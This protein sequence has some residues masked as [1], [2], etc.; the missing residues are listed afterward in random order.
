MNQNAVN[1]LQENKEKYSKEILIKQLQNSGYGEEDINEAVKDVFGDDVP[2]GASPTGEVK[3]AGFWI[4]WVAVLLDGFIFVI[5]IYLNVLLQLI[6]S[7][8]IHEKNSS[9]FYLVGYLPIPIMVVYYIFMTNKYQATLGK[10]ALGLKVVAED[11]QRAELGK[12]VLR[13]TVGKI[14]SAI[15]LGIGYIMAGFTQKKQALHDM[16]A[17]T[18]VVY[19][20]PSKKMRGWVVGVVIAAVILFMVV[21]V[22]ILAS[23]VLVGLDD[24][25]YEAQDA[26]VRATVS[27]VL[28]QALVYYG[29]DKTFDG[30]KVKGEENLPGC[31]EKKL[32]VNIAPDG[33]E[34]AIF[35]QL[36]SQKDTYFCL[37][38]SNNS[39]N[40][41]EV[42]GDYVR[43]GK[44]SCE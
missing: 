4:R 20:D 37:G 14:L 36:C 34:L 19:K 5:L 40:H 35:G 22:G 38:T 44:S 1:Y 8:F 7:G 25:R 6:L 30:F 21:V 41:L 3:Y 28:P 42:D 23:I 31:S 16:V 26:A 29:E 18:V 10:M 33:Q 2:T 17:G 43:S 24:A 12:I 27:T 9:I 15:T 39:A 13:E 11:G 32:V